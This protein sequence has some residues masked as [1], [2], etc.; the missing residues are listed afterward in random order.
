MRKNRI[1][2]YFF[3]AVFLLTAAFLW[4]K[5]A[6]KKENDLFSVRITSDGKSENIKCWQ[7]EKE[8]YYVFLPSYADLSKSKLFLNTEVELSINGKAIKDGMS[9]Q[10]FELNVP[11][12]LSYN[13]WGKGHSHRVTFLK[14]DN[15]ATMYIDTASGNMDYINSNKKNQESADLCV[16]NADGTLDYTGKIESISGRGNST[17]EL[18]EKKPYNIKFACDTNLLKIGEA[19]NWVL[20]AN[21]ADSS[22]LRNKLIYDFAKKIGLENSPDSEWV[23][24]YLNGEYAGLYLLSEKNEIHR[25]RV[26]INPNESFLVSTEYGYKLEKQNI[27]YITTN[28]GQVLRIRNSTYTPEQLIEKWQS[29]ENAILADDNEDT[30]SRKNLW[31]LID[32]DSWARKY[33]IEEVFINFDGGFVSQFFYKSGENG[34]IFA[35]PV[36]DYDLSMGRAETYQCNNPEALIANRLYSV[37]NYKTPWFNALYS[38]E[39]FLNRV[40]E[41]YATEFLP[42]LNKLVNN[43]I[44]EYSDGIAQ[45]S[46]MNSYRW[47]AEEDVTLHPQK[48]SDFM[49]K[50]I[51]FLNNIWI[52][53]GEYC[54]V[55]FDA[56]ADRYY[57][58]YCCYKG[59]V[60][61]QMPNLP[62]YPRVEFLGWYYVDTDEPFDINKPIYEDV[63][64]YAKWQEIGGEKIKDLIKLAPVG[65]ITVLFFA[66]CIV[67][68]KKY[69]KNSKVGK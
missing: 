50:R 54:T 34:K 58:Y 4:I 33:L 41:L 19:Q 63:E 47:F 55:K 12:N 40:K 38:N 35:G 23:D 13:T 8:D 29:V 26:N 2:V 66:L 27:P 6:D 14:S 69:R 25:N 42:E 21:A 37:D 51:E 1:I 20:L 31:E 18:Y 22:N 46:K 44:A 17:W 64:V 3:T 32:L 59:K 24:L 45:A 15:V 57:T 56:G 49:E 60:L 67:E 36:W 30:I 62:D 28:S 11:Y 65:V 68:F 10:S 53:N 43:G 48:M 16:V 39:E 5:I 9:C 61:S 52:N 7:N